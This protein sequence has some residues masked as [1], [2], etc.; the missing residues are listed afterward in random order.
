MFTF[1]M[2]FLSSFPLASHADVLKGS[3]WGRNAWR[4]P[5][6][7][8]VGGY[9]PSSRITM[10]RLSKFRKSRAVY[11]LLFN[12][13][14]FVYFTSVEKDPCVLIKYKVETCKSWFKTNCVEIFY[15][16]KTFWVCLQ[17]GDFLLPSIVAVSGLVVTCRSIVMNRFSCEKTMKIP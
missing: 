14:R 15:S 17:R 3:S 8:C 13:M 9:F 2:P 5:K 16:W 12:S 11:C 4:T 10:S 1:R 6:N 7:V